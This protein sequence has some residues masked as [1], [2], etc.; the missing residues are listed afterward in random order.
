MSCDFNPTT[1]VLATAGADCEV[2]LWRVSAGDGTPSAEVAVE[3]L[4]TLTGHA[5]SVNCARWNGRGDALATAGDA[6]DVYLWSRVGEE[7]TATNSHGD[8]VSWKPSRTLRG[9]RDDVL[10]LCWGPREQLATTSVD[11]TTIVWDTQSGQGLVQLSDHSHY[12]QGVAFDPRGEF[13]VSQ[14]PDRTMKVYS[15]R[16]KASSKSVRQISSLKS[17]EHQSLF[18][19]DGMTSFFRRPS[20]SPDGSVVAVPAG[21]FKRDGATQPMNA[22]FVFSRGDFSTPALTLPGGESPSVC[23]KFSPVIYQR[24]AGSNPTTS[25]DLPYRMVYAVCSQDA[26][27]VYDTDSLEPL[28]YVGA[29]H[30]ACITDCSWSPDGNI[31]FVT[32]TDGFATVIAFDGDELGSAVPKADLP[33]KLPIEDDDASVVVV[34]PEQTAPAK[35]TTIEPATRIAPTRIAPT[36]M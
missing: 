12:V 15:V 36:P 14:S 25:S 13:L 21:L 33:I 5:K 16:G 31:L 26:V 10:S 1:G 27:A 4:E 29:I 22:T 32:S 20:F 19:D 35:T 17:L 8:A 18:H 23:V 6:G 11:N 9:H 3:H 28:L 2:K 34:K 7:S 30:F 24:K